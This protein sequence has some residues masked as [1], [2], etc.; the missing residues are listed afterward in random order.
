MIEAILTPSF[1]IQFDVD[2]QPMPIQTIKQKEQL[3]VS[4]KVRIM[5]MINF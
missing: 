5:I 3:S 2:F 1:F 4:K